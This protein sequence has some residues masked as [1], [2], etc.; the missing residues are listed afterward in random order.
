LPAVFRA[1]FI[2]G[3]FDRA[4]IETLQKEESASTPGKTPTL[5]GQ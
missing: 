5:K 3:D 4:I 2:T 1:F